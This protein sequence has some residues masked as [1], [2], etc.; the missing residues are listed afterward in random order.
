[1]KTSKQGNVNPLLFVYGSRRHI[2]TKQSAGTRGRAACTRVMHAYTFHHTE[3]T[4]VRALPRV[5]AGMTGR[6]SSGRASSRPACGAH[7]RPAPRCSYT[8]TPS[9]DALCPALPRGM[10]W[11]RTRTPLSRR[12]PESPAVPVAPSPGCD[13]GVRGGGPGKA[14]G[15]AAQRCTRVGRWQDNLAGGLVTPRSVTMVTCFFL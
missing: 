14:G 9:P 6:V 4:P 1:M 10:P 8:C 13:S 2:T 12:I 11:R 7:P 15:A 5:W 3:Y